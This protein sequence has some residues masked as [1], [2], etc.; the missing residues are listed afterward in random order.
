MRLL[1]KVHVAEEYVRRETN[2]NRESLR[3]SGRGIHEP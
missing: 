2:V 1:N 3:E